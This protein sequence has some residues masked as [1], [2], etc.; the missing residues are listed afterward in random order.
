MILQ[1]LPNRKIEKAR[2][3]KPGIVIDF[4]ISEKSARFSQTFAPKSSFSSMFD[5]DLFPI[6]DVFSSPVHKPQENFTDWTNSD[7][8]M[9][10]YERPTSSQP[11]I[12]FGADTVNFE[13][14]FK[15][16]VAK[17]PERR[18]FVTPV[19]EAPVAPKR[20]RPVKRIRNVFRP[21][22]SVEAAEMTVQQLRALSANYG[23]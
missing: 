19:I 5:Y 12:D 7:M 21:F 2:E 10:G 13:E 8:S 17:E 18:K 15:M 3:C 23:L 9:P 22:V 14:A 1:N 6:T 20:K 16:S 4:T 11:F